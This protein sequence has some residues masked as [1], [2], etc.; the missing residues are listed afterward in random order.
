MENIY[1]TIK[2]PINS[3]KQY[4]K[5]HLM[6]LI[7]VLIF[8][9]FIF[10][11]GSGTVSAAAGDTIY[12]NVHGNDSWNGQS[13]VWDGHSGPKLSLRNATGDVNRGGTVKIANGLYYGGKNAKIIIAKNMKIIGESKT[14]TIINGTDNNW[15]FLIKP[16]INV[17]ITNL[18]LSNG[19][20][21][22]SGGAINNFGTLFVTNSTFR[23]NRAYGGGAIINHIDANLIVKGCKFTVNTATFGGAVENGGKMTVTRSAF[24]NNTAVDGGAIDNA[25]TLSVTESK[26]INN[27]ASEGGGAIANYEG[28]L[29]LHFNQ[30][31]GN[32]ATWGS[33]IL[34]GKG[35]ADLSLNW[36][37]SNK[38]PLNNVAGTR[39]VGP[40]L[41]LYLS[42]K[43]NLIKNNGISIINAD[44]VHDSINVS[45]NPVNG[46][47]PWGIVVKFKTTLGTINSTVNFINGVSHAIL[48]SGTVDGVADISASVDHQTVSTSVIIDTA[49]RV[50]NIYTLNNS[51]KVPSNT[52]IQITFSEPIKSGNMHIELQKTNKT[53]ISLTTTITGNI[54]TIKHPPL[55][56]GKY[57][58][59]LY[60]GCITDLGGLSLKDMTMT[61][62]VHNTKDK[63][64][65]GRFNGLLSYLRS[66]PKGFKY[67][68][69]II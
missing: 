42:A 64:S 65:T 49:P 12:V 68:I 47:V 2:A 14:G 27:H 56:N 45:H 15:I 33:A 30:I 69:N 5:D 50:M 17:N 25:D 19:K 62:K 57:T 51:K 3:T 23:S 9:L 46:H 24:R 36:W 48:R 18:V 21:T 1:W 8:I 32:S 31:V 6:N 60:N 66:T 10:S 38:G 29:T 22:K 37:G 54:L 67:L 44:L 16:G 40:W 61:F 34:H 13:S 4:L 41:V 52:A 55:T 53:P 35:T 11:Y 39:K 7:L 43:P 28:Y 63:L 59:K 20:S 26:F 58:L